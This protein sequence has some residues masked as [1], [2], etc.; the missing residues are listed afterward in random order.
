MKKCDL[1]N[2][3]LWKNLNCEEMWFNNFRIVM[4]CE[5]G[6]FELSRNLNKC[7][8]GNFELWRNLNC[9]EMWVTTFWIV[10]KFELRRNI[11]Y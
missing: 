10:K 3:E 9:E 8:L 11:I 5:L 4:K 6:H 2:V 1:E 7:E